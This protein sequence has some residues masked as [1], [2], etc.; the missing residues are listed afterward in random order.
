M[1]TTWRVLY[2]GPDA[3][4]GVQLAI[5]ALLATLDDQL[6]HWNPASRLCAFNRAPAGSWITLPHHLASVMDTALRVAA[7]SNGAFDP[8]IGALVDLWGFGPPGPKPTPDDAAISEA[9]AVSGWRRLRW[10]PAARRLRQPGGLSLD[11]SGIAK[12][13]AA[14]AIADLLG[15][16]GLVHALVE[17]GGELVG[18]GVQPDG[19]PWWVDLESPP[20]LNVE[21]IRAALHGIAVATSGNYVRGAHSIDP[22]NGRPSDNNVASVSVLAETAML[23]DALATA[24][25]I[26]FPNDDF[27][28][29]NVAARIITHADSGAVEHLTPAMARMLC[30]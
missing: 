21:P 11:L 12:G 15:A 2:V 14:D 4:D 26:A 28:D 30:M 25:T 6:S 24:W 18:R 9:L 13:Y 29:M 7:V 19:S 23:A 17:V 1:G 8:S 16:R 3:P 22:R 20:G 27:R 10:D 5:K